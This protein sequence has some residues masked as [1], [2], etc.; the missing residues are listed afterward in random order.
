MEYFSK[1]CLLKLVIKYIFEQKINNKKK[2][3]SKSRTLFFIF[4]FE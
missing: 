4:F 1:S 2:T 3:G